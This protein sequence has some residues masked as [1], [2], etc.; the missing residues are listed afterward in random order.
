ME[1]GYGEA[2][3]RTVREGGRK[4][5]RSFVKVGRDLLREEQE[6]NVFF[7]GPEKHWKVIADIALLK[8]WDSAS[9]H[10]S[11]VAASARLLSLRRSDAPLRSSYLEIAHDSGMTT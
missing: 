6:K 8:L 4:R 10:A 3:S 7:S 11:T 2:L 5:M 1:H 9:S